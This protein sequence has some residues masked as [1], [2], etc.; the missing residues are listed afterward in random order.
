MSQILLREFE[1]GSKIKGANGAINGHSVG[2]KAR[3]PRGGV[4]RA[5]S[6]CADA[7]K[8]DR[9]NSRK[10]PNA[11]NGRSAA[12][13]TWRFPTRG[14]LTGEARDRL[15]IVAIFAVPAIEGGVAF[16][17]GLIG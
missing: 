5:K 17:R 11:N 4:S 15:L 8:V 3:K 12:R 10:R 1:H 16:M 6:V 14:W 7:R 2:G 9:R 13:K